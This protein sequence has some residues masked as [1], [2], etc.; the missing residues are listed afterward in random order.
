VTVIT[1]YFG[2]QRTQTV[3]LAAALSVCEMSYLVNCSLLEFEQRCIFHFD[4]ICTH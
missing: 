1:V 4:F 3:V 2:S